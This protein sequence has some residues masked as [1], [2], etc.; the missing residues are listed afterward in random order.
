MPALSRYDPPTAA[1]LSSDRRGIRWLAG[2]MAAAAFTIVTI[3]TSCASAP[4][5][6]I[7]SQDGRARAV[8]K[9]EIANTQSARE[10]GLMYR[11]KLAA[12]AGMLFVFSGPSMLQFWMKNTEIPLDM[13]F[14]NGDG[15]IVGIIANA[16]PYSEKRLSV[17]APSVYVLEV[18]GGFCAQ[19]GIETGDRIRFDGFVPRSLD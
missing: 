5:V 9:V 19:H 17:D 12:N 1:V 13:I 8:V 11:P 3:A 2:L 14:A 18:N 6:E 15:R 16:E 7:L 4:R 10:V